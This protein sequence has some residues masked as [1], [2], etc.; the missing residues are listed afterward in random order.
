MHI[1]VHCLVRTNLAL[2]LLYDVFEILQIIFMHIFLFIEM[3][4]NSTL[5]SIIARFA[6][7][8]FPSSFLAL[9][10]FPQLIRT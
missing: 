8:D 9:E 3:M 7:V 2:E 6:G 5:Q 1:L 10:F 4:I